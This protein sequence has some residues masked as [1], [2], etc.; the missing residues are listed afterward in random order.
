MTIKGWRKI[1]YAFLL[2][3]FSGLCYAQSGKPADFIRVRLSVVAQGIGYGLGKDA[4]KNECF[5]ALATVTNT[6][7]TAIEITFAGCGWPYINWMTNTENVF[8]RISGCDAQEIEHIILKPKQTIEFNVALSLR[9]KKTKVDSV[10]LGF[11]YSAEGIN[12]FNKKDPG[13]P[14]FW[15]NEVKLVNALNTYRVSD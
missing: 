8:L 2:M 12:M 4:A 1:G 6:Q 11:V 7:D 14:V 15:S 10:K 9:N 13:L 3:M 5:F